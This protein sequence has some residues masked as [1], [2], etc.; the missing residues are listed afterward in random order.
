MSLLFSSARQQI[1]PIA[2]MLNLWQLYE[3]VARIRR[4]V[5]LVLRESYEE[6][7]K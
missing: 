5:S 1:F 6:N 3:Y 2:D 4:D 7:H